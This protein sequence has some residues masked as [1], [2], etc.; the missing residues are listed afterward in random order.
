MSSLYTTYRFS[1]APSA[2]FLNFILILILSMAGH[3]APAPDRTRF[4]FLDTSSHP[5]PGASS[6]ITIVGRDSAGRFCHLD[7]DG[8]LQPCSAADNTVELNGSLWCAYSMPLRDGCCRIDIDRDL[9]MDS[10]RAYLSV[11]GPLRLRVDPGTGA[12]VQPDP[13]NRSDPNA[14]LSYDWIEFALDGAGFHGNTT[15]V[16]QF[17]L[18]VSL[19]VIERGEPQRRLGPVGIQEARSAI[20]RAWQAEVP[21]PFQALAEPGGQ[22]ILA[23][24]HGPQAGSHACNHYF[25]ASITRMWEKYAS[26]PLILSPEEGTFSG[27]VQADGR[28]LFTRAGD[29]LRYVIAARPSTAEVFRCDGVLARGSSLEKVLGAQLAA[30]LN[31]N[32]EDPLAWKNAAGYYRQA[33]CNGY[34]RF[35]HQHGLAG[36]A[37]GF[38]Y[39][40]VNDQSPSLASADPMEIQIAF[41]CD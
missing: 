20:L 37:Y 3:S 34:A 32:V 28:L 6:Y 9:R 16:D 41:R 13:G 39:D 19:T 18:P 30:I 5:S 7:P 2:R 22:R 17:G 23:P 4:T 40:D 11:G 8:R 33:P 21:E 26:E 27:W 31:R 12:L 38:P 24:S 36:K 15:C 35:W 10:A 29:P 14:G 25:D 1:N